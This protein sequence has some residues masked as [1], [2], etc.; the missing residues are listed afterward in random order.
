MRLWVD[1]ER[2][3]ED[4]L[5]HIRWF[6]DRDPAQLGEWVWV[7]TAD[8]A[9]A[10]LASENVVGVSLDHD[11]GTDQ[12][13]GSV[14]ASWIEERALRRKTATC[15]RSD[16]CIPRTRGACE[17]RGGRVEHRAARHGEA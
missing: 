12:A 17:A 2:D 9:I 1:D 15:R 8:E 4:W 13:D 7:R 3:P 6:R 5:P 11:L 14:I 16:A 10:L